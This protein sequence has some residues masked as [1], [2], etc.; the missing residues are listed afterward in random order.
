MV[1]REKVIAAALSIV[2][3]VGLAGCSGK[4]QTASQADPVDGD[5][6]FDLSAT[7]S[8]D[9]EAVWSDDGGVLWRA[10]FAKKWK[11]AMTAD[12][13]DPDKQYTLTVSPTDGDGE[14]SCRVVR[15]NRLI[16][17]KHSSDDKPATCT[18]PTWEA[19]SRNLNDGDYPLVA[20]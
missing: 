10:R 6:G 13:Y 12:D 18:F 2:L 1:N 3:M 14:V 5:P 16:D 20:E 4:R 9:A 19:W 8:G 15:M 17:D 7:A 11:R